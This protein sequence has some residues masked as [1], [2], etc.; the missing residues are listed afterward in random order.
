MDPLVSVVIPARNAAATLPRAVRSVLAQAY[1]V[2]VIVVD[3]ASADGTAALAAALGARVV[4]LDRRGGAAAARNAGIAAARGG[5]IAFQDADDEWLPGK[6]RRQVALLCAAPDAAFAACGARLVGQDGGDLGPLYGGAVPEAGA[7]AWR[8]L[9]ARNTI[10][11]PSVV[12]WRRSLDAV[13]PFDPALPVAEDQD[14]WLRLAMH[15]RLVYLDE[16]LVRVHVTTSSVS[17][18]GTARGS[19]QQ[20]AI[21]LP[22]VRRHLTARLGDLSRREVRAILAAR[23]GRVGRASYG[24][25][26]YR[27]GLALVARATWY[28][29]PPIGNVRFLLSASPFG[30]W[31]K[32]NVLGR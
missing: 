2:D 1:P 23:L 18:V 5:L 31:V 3:D 26:D 20:R 8:A 24:D 32:R 25:R 17:G 14:M 27:A 30:R 28:G 12:A 6:L 7:Q 13:G 11:T 22:M 16:H 21:T 10:A 19:R 29:D 4:R 9:L 15:G